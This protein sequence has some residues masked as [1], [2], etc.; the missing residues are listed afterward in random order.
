MAGTRKA[1]RQNGQTRQN[2]RSAT[3]HTRTIEE[4]LVHLDAGSL[5]DDHCDEKNEVAKP[6]QEQGGRIWDR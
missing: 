3:P 4:E 2:S 6:Q 5:G 1:H